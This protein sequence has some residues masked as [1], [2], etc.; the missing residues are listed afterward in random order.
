[1]RKL[2][3][4]GVGFGALI[5]P[6][7]A[8]DVAPYYRAPP[9][10]PVWGW[11]GFYIGANAGWIGSTGNSLNNTGTDT[12]GR[13]L[14]TDLA[15]GA[16]P[17]SV[18]LRENGFMGGGQV[19]Y[20]W[21][22]GPSWLWG[23]EADFGGVVGAKTSTTATFLGAGRGGI[24]PLATVYNRE[25]D[26]LGTVRGR[27]GFLF[28]PNLLWYATGGLAYGQTKAG[29]AFVCALC[30]PPSGTE[31]GTVAQSPNTSIGWTLGAGVEWRFA[32]AWSVKAEYLY[33]DLGSQSNTI[34]Y[35]YSQ[36]APKLPPFVSTLTSNVNERDNLVRMGINY[37]FGS[38]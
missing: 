38:Y 14:G 22:I 29:V 6:A 8:A 17:S 26:T 9:P 25:L 28:T 19:G 21:Q 11:T 27:L 20:N 10:L 24:L 34:T 37:N 32:P 7:M 4:A 36:S 12:G 31:G 35:T 3:L 1:M 18:N 30:G 23:I 16:I 33:V 13:G 15:A 5:M 2:L